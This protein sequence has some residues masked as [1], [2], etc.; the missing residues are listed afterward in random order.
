[1]APGA[2]RHVEVK[3]LQSWTNR[4]I[5]EAGAMF[6][7]LVAP[8]AAIFYFLSERDA[9]RFMPL[10][11]LIGGVLL[12]LVGMSAPHYTFRGLRAARPRFFIE[13]LLVCALSV[14]A[15]IG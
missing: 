9:A 15:A 7:A 4:T 11:S 6:L 13:A 8:H 14:G 10:T 2:L 3:A 12:I 1:M 5:L